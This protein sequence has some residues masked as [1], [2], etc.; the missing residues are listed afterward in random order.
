VMQEL[1]GKR[2]YCGSMLWARVPS[3]KTG[4]PRA[5]LIEFEPVVLELYRTGYGYRAIA[6]ILRTDYQINPDFSTVKRELVRLGVLP[7][8]GSP[9]KPLSG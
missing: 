6:R 1:N 2:R 4:R 9:A 3:H 7:H 8:I 5:I